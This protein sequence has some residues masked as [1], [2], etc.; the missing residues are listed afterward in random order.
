MVTVLI[1]V[2]LAFWVLAF[3]AMAIV[4]LV[5][6]GKRRDQPISAEPA[7]APQAE[8]QVLSILPIRPGRPSPILDRLPARRPARPA[9][10]QRRAA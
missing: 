1:D 4:P 3:G 6:G 7:Q 5:L 2:L 8:D 10:D 9:A